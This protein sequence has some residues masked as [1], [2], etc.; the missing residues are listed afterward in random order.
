MIEHM[1]SRIEAL[2]E[3]NK[4]AEDKDEKWEQ[5]GRKTNLWI[6]G[7]EEEE[8]ENTRQTERILHQRL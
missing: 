2:D 3:E 4:L 7:L 6:Y 5:H 8:N 1:H